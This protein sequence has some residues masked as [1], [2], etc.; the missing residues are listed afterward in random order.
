[1]KIV[2]VGGVAAG[3]SAAARARRLAESA[4]IVVLERDEHVSFANCGLP[5]YLGGD[6][7]DRDALLLQTPRSLAATLALDVRTRSE[8]VAVDR[9][10]RR[11]L[12]R[13]LR[14]G[15]EYHEPYDRLV[16]AT[17]ARPL[18]PDLPGA[19]HPRV[20]TMRT[21][22]DTDGL[23]DLVR[24]G[25]VRQALVVGGGYI[26]VEVAEALRHRDVAVTLVELAPQ[27][28]GPLDAELAQL[29]ADE[30]VR[31][32]VDVRTGVAVKGFTPDA[33]AP[34]TRLTAHLADGSDVAADLVLLGAGVVPDTALARAAGLALTDRGAVVVDRHQ[35]TS[36]PY[37]YAAGDSVAVTD[38][39]TGAVGVV[40]LAGPANRQ[41]RIAAECL[42]GR[43][44]EYPGT[45]GTSVVKAFDLTAAATGANEKTLRRAGIEHHVVYT[46]PNGHA[47]YYPGTAAMH[48]KL[49]FAPGDGRVLGAQIVGRDGVDKRIDVL[50]VALRAGLTVFDLEQ[51][52][53]AYAPP[54][55]SAKDPVNMAGFQ[56]ANLLRGDVRFW[57]PR[58]W[59]ALPAH[60]QL[61]DVRSPA[62]HEHCSLPGS[63]LVPLPTLRDRVGELDP[64]RPVRL[65]CASGFRSY[66][67]YRVLVQHGFSDVATL[68]GG[69]M[70]M[71][72]AV[73]QL[74]R[75]V[76]APAA[77]APIVT[78]AETGSGCELDELF[79]VA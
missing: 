32:G 26:G 55:G 60:T 46:H 73:P 14:T 21:V 40:P 13:D 70:T 66:L 52:E 20:R 65:Y 63:L 54:Y 23:V 42:L 31:H 18:R 71:R 53:L 76:G 39:V 67:A 37:I 34:S 28:M 27:L 3:M 61:V 45:Q 29:V 6:I 49:L 47:S 51:L 30:L 43:D 68:S 62:E 58:D 33:N 7:G 5:Y 16:L 15:A 72:A 36:D 78:Y 11:V 35:R 59:A 56:A 19:D 69:T 22:G 41:G 64:H 79:A 44:S 74:R 12:V 1:V 77:T 57:Y 25:Q 24:A 50:A 38:P 75:V 4:D 48:L 8:A 17:G 9:A 2:V 10:A